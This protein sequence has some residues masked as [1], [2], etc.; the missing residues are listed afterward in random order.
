MP[1]PRKKAAA[2]KPEAV[3]GPGPVE[4]VPPEVVVTVSGLTSVAGVKPGGR[5]PWDGDLV[6]L[7]GLML[8]GYVT[9]TVGGETISD[10]HIVARMEGA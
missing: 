3:E 4:P 9:V 10:G 7:R 1:V 5:L 2:V 6:R 8:G